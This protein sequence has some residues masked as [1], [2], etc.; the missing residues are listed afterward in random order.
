MLVLFFK[1]EDLFLEIERGHLG[2]V[3][4]VQVGRKACRMSSAPDCS[5]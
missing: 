1:L 3:F 5:S 4:V 2:F